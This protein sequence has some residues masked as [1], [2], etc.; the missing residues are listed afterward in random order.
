MDH[1][2]VSQPPILEMAL[3]AIQE[4][5]L[6]ATLTKAVDVLPWARSNY[7]LVLW[8]RSAVSSLVPV[9]RY[10]CGRGRATGDNAHCR[11]LL[12][13][14]R[15]YPSAKSQTGLGGSRSRERPLSDLDIK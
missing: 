9:Q 5:A 10:D 14:T 11:F 13:L 2:C 3:V 1:T 6:R 4:T 8:P 15:D 12:P 7:S